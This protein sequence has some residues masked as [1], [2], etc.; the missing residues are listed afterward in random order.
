MRRLAPLIVVVLFACGPGG[1][2]GAVK[3]APVTAS[4]AISIQASPALSSP[5]PT[6]AP[7]SPSKA[8]L[9][10]SGQPAAAQALAL[11]YVYTTQQSDL[12]VVDVSDP[13][14]PVL[15]CTLGPAQGGRF[16]SAS[17][18][19]FWSGNTLDAADLVSG[20]VV[21]TLELP[22]AATIGAVSAD[23]TEVAYRVLDH[24]GGYT[25]HLYIGGS[26]GLGSSIDRTLYDQQA[27]DGF[28]G[29]RQ[30]LGPLGQLQF[31]P[32][33]KELLD[34]SMFS[35][36]SRLANLLVFKVDGSI[37]FQESG[38]APGVWSATGSVLYFP[39]TNQSGPTGEIDSLDSAGQR[40]TVATGLKDFWLP[41]LS[42]DGRSIVYNTPDVSVAD[43]VGL[44]HLWRLNLSTGN[45]SQLSTAISSGAVFVGR[46]VVW[47]NEE[48]LTR[49]G[50][51]GPAAGDG[52]VLAHNL[53]TGIDTA[54]DS[55]FIKT[56]AGEPANYLSTNFVLD[57]K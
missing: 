1:T 19:A 38:Q 50:P 9:K 35:P 4:P 7:S 15:L 57:V 47:S 36:T 31:S 34:Y 46:N 6:T 30:D 55:G 54:V 51:G 41:T 52:V 16:L 24:A 40:R 32:D 23:G 33:G 25:A 45:T 13:T 28:E 14:K 10:C 37:L 5:S 29:V 22:A 27:I 8:S 3:S 39:V 21:Q 20:D 56:A 18:I 12:N 49:C 44:P 2:Q 42:P 53:T 26:S 11:F 48:K 17:K 43:C